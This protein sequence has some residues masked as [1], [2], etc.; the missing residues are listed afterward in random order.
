MKIEYNKLLIPFKVKSFVKGICK[1]ISVIAIAI[2]PSL[3][4]SILFLENF[5]KKQSS[6]Y[7]NSVSLSF[8]FLLFYN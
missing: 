8:Y 6:P 2:T 7:A 5:I 4:D 3:N 1:T